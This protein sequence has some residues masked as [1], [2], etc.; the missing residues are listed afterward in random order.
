MEA[1]GNG[2]APTAARAKRGA[3]TREAILAR[4][5][6]LASVEGLE[7]LTIGRLASEMEMSK[8]GLFRH[9]GSKE[10][11]QLATVDAASQV[12]VA[13]V[14]EPALQEDEGA[15]RLRAL[16][17]RYL[18]HLESGV[19]AGGC[20][21]AATASEFDSRPGPVRD[22]VRE[23][24][25]AWIGALARVA[26]AAGVDDPDQLAFEIHSVAQGANQRHQ[27]FGDAAAFDRART[28]FDRLLP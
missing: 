13:E 22:R 18:D 11:L 17:E 5:V 10:E 28:T 3:T 19:F 21:W 8:S 6:D 4:A 16:C 1:M 2:S 15:A 7:G 14:V 23:A 25:D 27:L 20:F 26:R 12:F 9:F 24:L